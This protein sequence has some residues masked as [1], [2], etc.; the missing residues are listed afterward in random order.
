MSRSSKP[1]GPPAHLGRAGAATWRAIVEAVDVEAHDR[2]VPLRL[3]CEAVDRYD[4][5]GGQ[6]D[7]EGLTV[8]TAHG[9]KTH[10]AVAVERDARAAVAA[11]WKLLE[12]D[13]LTD[14]MGAP[15]TT[16]PAERARVRRGHG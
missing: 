14:P 2:L 16:T 11:L 13:N 3:L 10:P 12:L 15:S 5:A 6:L 1:P 9:L 8:A 7:R 4:G